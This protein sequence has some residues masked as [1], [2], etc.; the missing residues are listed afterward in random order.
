MIS[1]VTPSE[2]GHHSALAWV[3]MIV[4]LTAPTKAMVEKMTGIQK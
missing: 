1:K 2:V 3:V 4:S